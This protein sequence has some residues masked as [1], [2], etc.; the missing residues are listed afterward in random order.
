MISPVDVLTTRRLQLAL[1]LPIRGDTRA[2]IALV[3][4][5]RLIRAREHIGIEVDAVWP[6]HRPCNPI[7]RD[8]REH[9]VVVDRRQDLRQRTGEVDLTNFDPQPADW[10][11]VGDGEEPSIRGRVANPRWGFGFVRFRGVPWSMSG[12]SY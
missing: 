2:A 11:K 3:Q 6:A 1:S 5:L 4:A 7:D 8:G 10:V 9:I 12:P